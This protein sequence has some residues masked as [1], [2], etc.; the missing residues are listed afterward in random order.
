MRRWLH[1]EYIPGKQGYAPGIPPPPM[2]VRAAGK[3]NRKNGG[4]RRKDEFGAIQ[5]PKEPRPARSLQQIEKATMAELRRTYQL[6]SIIER[7]KKAA[8]DN[9]R[10]LAQKKRAAEATARPVKPLSISET[11]TRPSIDA[12]FREQQKMTILAKDGRKAFEQAEEM[13]TRT[14]S[15]LINLYHACPDFVLTE[16]ELEDAIKEA[17]SRQTGMVGPSSA[18][19]MVDMNAYLDAVGPKSIGPSSARTMGGRYRRKL[20]T[21]IAD[22]LMGTAGEG[23]VGPVEIQAALGKDA[24]KEQNDEVGGSRRDVNKVKE[25]KNT[26]FIAPENSGAYD[27][28]AR[29]ESQQQSLMEA[30]RNNKNRSSRRRRKE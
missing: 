7:Q 1:V 2:L 21:R 17:F 18:M 12:Q 19:S 24:P 15:I 30:A 4:S 20:Q 14:D 8:L 6:E 10:L 28:K 11:L 9:E 13:Q 26:Y 23:N 16:A 5:T 27:M 22:E 3:T 29:E 25:L